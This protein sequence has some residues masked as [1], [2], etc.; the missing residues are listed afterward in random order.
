MLL[1]EEVYKMLNWGFGSVMATQFIF[2]IG[3]WLNHKFDARSFVYI[4]IYLALFTFAGY[5][6]LMAI[7]TT[8][9]EEASFNLTIA[10]ILWVLS[11]LFLLLSIFRLVRIRK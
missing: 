1:K 7:N 3:L 6:L 8:G 9:S 4:I 10:G 11:V 2:V 5:S